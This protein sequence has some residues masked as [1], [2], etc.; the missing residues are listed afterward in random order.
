MKTIFLILLLML[1][2]WAKEPVKKE[3]LVM[4]FTHMEHCGWCERMQKETIDDKEAL[5]EIKENFMLT[6]IKKESGNMPSFLHPELFPTVYILSTDGNKVIEK[7]EAYMKKDKF[8]K[9][10]KTLYEIETTPETDPDLKD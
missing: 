2:S 8:L 1:S 7:L 6:K 4:I 9:Y 3:K 5:K 10:T